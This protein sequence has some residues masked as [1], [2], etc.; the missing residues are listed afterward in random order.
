M[1]VRKKQYYDK[2]CGAAALLCAA[3]ELGI[4]HLPTIA[5]TAMQGQELQADNF[6]E[7]ALYYLTSGSSLG[8]RPVGMD[9]NKGGYSFPHNL[10]LA[11][12][13]IGLDAQIYMASTYST[14]LVS[15][16]YPRCESLCEQSGVSV[17][18]R[19]PP[20]LSH[21]ERLL[22]IMGVMK[23]LGLHYVMQRPDYTYM[24][25]ADGQDY[26]S[27]RELN[28][29]WLKCYMDIGISILLKKS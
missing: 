27:F 25:P 26:Y 8:A 28:N 29:S 13:L 21:A 11:A 14:K 10:V 6:C 5:G 20:P 23:M 19:E 3:K 15:M 2:S 17:F 22:K 1:S 18:H 9:L 4:R 24:D 12:R 7:S 16:L